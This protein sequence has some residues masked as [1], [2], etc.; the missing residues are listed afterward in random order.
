VRTTFTVFF[1]TLLAAISVAAHWGGA[2]SWE[3]D[4]LFYQAKTEEI[5]GEDAAAARQQVFGGPLSDY[6]RQLELEASGEPPRVG[7]PAWVEYSAP[8]YARRL[9][10]PALAAA[11]HPVLGINALETLSLLAFILIPGLL[12]LLLRRRL[13][14]SASFLVAAAT[15]LWPPLRAW[16]VF[17]LADSSGVALLIAALLCGLFTIERGS[18]WLVPWTL[19]VLALAFTRDLAFMPVIAALALL[20]VRRDRRSAALVGCGI[21]AAIPALLV[22]TV[23]ES[24]QL[25]YVFADHAIPTDTSWGSVI[26]QYPGNLG[27]M[28]GRYADYAAANPQVVLLAICGV[29]AAFALAPRRD[30]LTILVWATFPGYLLLLAIGPSFSSFRYELVLLPLIAFGYGHVAERVIPRLRDLASRYAGSRG[31]LTPL[32]SAHSELPATSGSEK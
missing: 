32:G 5:R 16:S 12:F 1:L 19:C 9:L 28:A 17:P 2:V 3:T 20:A 27:H 21:A 11:L 23:S 15:I 31:R 6:E 10:L 26:S 4:A 14:F 30:S 7:D 25:A 18:R 22:Q 8:F 24:K 13:S 29:V